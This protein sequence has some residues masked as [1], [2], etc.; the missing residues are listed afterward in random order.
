MDTVFAVERI[1]E[2]GGVTFLLRG[3]IDV[4]A[5]AEFRSIPDRATAPVIRFDFSQVGR[6]NSMGI[7]HL[8]RCFKKIKDTTRSEIIL[9]GLST[10]HSM[11]F[12]TTGVFLLASHDSNRP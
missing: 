9:S 2:E 4:H 6:I 11:L 10:V 8:L 7:A 12:K 3:N 5:E 1:E